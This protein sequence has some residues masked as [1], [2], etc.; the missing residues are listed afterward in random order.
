[1][2]EARP[3]GLSDPTSQM[4]SVMYPKQ[5]KDVA[6][7]P[8]GTTSQHES[9]TNRAMPGSRERYISTKKVG[10]HSITMQTSAR[11]YE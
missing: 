4:K 7:S 10:E 8:S 6:S 3:W 11:Q 5:A 1:M 2:M 9:H